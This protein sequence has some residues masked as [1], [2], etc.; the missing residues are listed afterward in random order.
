VNGTAAE[1]AGLAPPLRSP[2]ALLAAER[3]RQGLGRADIAQR[4]HMSVAQVE[5]LESGDYARLPRGT[6]LRGFTR[7]YA[8][9]L[10][11]DAEA[12]VGMLADDAPRDAA[13]GIVVPSQNIRFDP[14]GERLA[15]PYVKAAGV[16]MAVIVLGFAAMYWWVFIRPQAGA[17]AARPAVQAPQVAP[18]N[19]PVEAPKT[20]AA[21][22]QEGAPADAGAAP[23]P[24][25]AAPAGAAP[26]PAEPGAAP[27]ASSAAPATPSAPAAGAKGAGTTPTPETAPVAAAPGEGLLRFTFRGAAWVEVTD[28]RGKIL[29]SRTHAPGS[30][31]E[32]AGRPPL[33]LVIGNAAEVR[34][35]YNGRPVDLE[36]HTRVAVARLT[37]P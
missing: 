29:V 33:G 31:A 35:T 32:V 21:T 24:A 15:N 14:L 5:A 26:A 20:G 7:N 13:P 10:G 12:L 27:P 18:A 16:A 37:L 22:R 6:F 1:D 9:A 34:L 30:S 25:P 4:L 28:G 19:A 8:R 2:G 23:S 17:P 3:E 36:P 11:M